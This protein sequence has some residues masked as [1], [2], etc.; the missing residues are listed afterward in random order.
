MWHP[1]PARKRWVL[2]KIVLEQPG[3]WK[4]SSW[5]LYLTPYATI[6]FKMG[7]DLNIKKRKETIPVAGGRAS[8]PGSQIQKS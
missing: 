1:A 6:L 7:K 3:S 4:K 8:K 2:Q 5:L